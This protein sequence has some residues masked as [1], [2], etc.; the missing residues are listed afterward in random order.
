MNADNS[1]AGDGDAAHV[2]PASASAPPAVA[3]SILART[4][5]AESA[6]TE[7]DSLRANLGLSV[8]NQDALEKD[9]MQ[10][11]D[12]EM[13]ER[14]RQL[15]EKRLFK[16]RQSIQQLH[17]QIG[18]AEATVEDGRTRI[19]EQNRV[20]RKLKGMN[21]E[22][23]SLMEDEVQ[24]M[25]RLQ[26]HLPASASGVEAGS[27]SLRPGAGEETERERLIRT[28]KITPFATDQDVAHLTSSSPQKVGRNVALAAT[29]AVPSSPLAER[30]DLSDQEP[31]AGHKRKRRLVRHTSA[32][33]SESDDDA[34]VDQSPRASD[35]DESAE[36]ASAEDVPSAGSAKKQYTDFY[37][38][39]GDE[40]VYQE[41]LQKWAK[42][43]Y[44]QRTG[45]RDYDGEDGDDVSLQGAGEDAGGA[46]FDADREM[47][48][49]SDVPDVQIA[50]QLRLPGE[51]HASLFQYQQTCL[52]WL[53]ELH[54]Q[55]VGGIIGDEMG[56]GKTVQIIAWLI[57]LSYSGHLRRPTLIVCPATV[58][59][60]WVKEFHKWWAPFRVVVLHASGSGTPTA[61]AGRNGDVS[62][63]DSDVEKDVRKKRFRSEPWVKELVDRVFEHGH[64]VVTTFTGIRIYQDQLL[65]RRW[66]YV[67]LDEGHK[68]RNPDAEVT[69]A[70]KQARTPHRIILSGT[71][72][73]NNL[74]ELWSLFDFVYPGRLGTLPVFQSEFAIPINLGGYVNATNVQVQTAYKCAV[75]L[76]DLINPYLLRRMKVDVAT[77]L[78]HKSEQVLFCKLTPEQ[79]ARYKEFLNSKD[80]DA[81]YQGNRQALYGIDVL[82]K[83]CNH[84][85]L[86][87]LKAPHRGSEFGDYR[88]SG[89]MLVVKALLD[90]W[91]KERH[92]VLLFM[93]TRQMMDIMEGMM[94]QQSFSYRRMDGTTPVKR[95]A[96]MVDEFNSKPS[97][98][99]FLLTTKV[100]GLGINLTGAN[101]VLIF[102][103]DWNPST[104]MQ[105]RERA[106]RLGQTR[107][108]TIYRLMTTGTIEEKIYHRQ[109]FKQFLTNKILKDPKQRR[110]F[111]VN[112]LQDLF[113]LGDDTAQTTETG[114]LFEDAQTAMQDSASEAT[115]VQQ[116]NGGEERS[117]TDMLK[118]LLGDKMHSTLQHDSIV[119]AARPE[120]IIVEQEAQRVASRAITALK[121]SRRERR[122]D[123]VAVPT[124]T[125][126]FGQAGAPRLPGSSSQPATNRLSVGSGSSK[127]SSSALLGNLR[128]LASIDDGGASSGSGSSSSTAATV[129]T[130]NGENPESLI[131]KIRDYLYEHGGRATSADIVQKFQLKIKGEDVAVFRKM[132]QGIATFEKTGGG[133]G[134]WTLQR[135]FY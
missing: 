135:D 9:I 133:K 91:H 109:I 51:V 41:R 70:C 17:S 101:R 18:K 26:A 47:F 38:D 43:R 58:M 108:V 14:D 107:Q 44:R 15:D 37:P 55:Q 52:R 25:E 46:P 82:R 131:V 97:L 74:T 34:Y 87:A 36:D 105:A 56:L 102:D 130:L 126:R 127:P 90:M 69:L 128:K 32:Y 113:T 49:P 10:Q 111:K 124:W 42:R 115:D 132:L 92:K 96:A 65:S 3:S 39:D 104:D 123:G 53:W 7:L 27:S 72:I 63:D 57:A 99:V 62:T 4:V 21:D 31:A 30:S 19:S 40:T 83:I 11:A 125:G 117:E 13:A 59:K 88:R 1:A 134:W 80:M 114:E 81:I 94:R 79:K 116:L 24:I 8:Y 6:E 89:K 22:L 2:V 76:R 120:T 35:E 73:Q 60:Q 50:D 95:R 85:D 67:I 28:G 98:F 119:D 100:G 112:D 66:S 20:R 77:D 86:L 122:Q 121:E 5:E 71:P 23:A 48:L 110:F 129:A 64:I 75:I 33:S 106:W 84:P 118:S 103:P 12:A 29:L 78:P 68:I 54:R 16:T 93:Q 61:R 45:K